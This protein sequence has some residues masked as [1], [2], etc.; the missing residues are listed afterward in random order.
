MLRTSIALAM[1]T[2]LSATAFAQAP[3][4]LGRP[5]ALSLA[6]VASGLAGGV[7]TVFVLDEVLSLAGVSDDV[8]V[9]IS[10]VTYPLGTSVGV[11]V[12]GRERGPDGTYGGAFRGA[13]R[14]AL[15]GY[16]AG[17]VVALA[18]VGTGRSFES[19]AAG[20]AVGLAVA[21]VGPPI[22]SALGYSVSAVSLRQPDGSA[23]GLSLRLDL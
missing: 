18:V 14:G 12:A 13:L 5:P 15:F 22:G 3:D 2:L 8:R 17:A 19:V 10:M 16:G 9:P 21:M 11:Y 6:L 23:P 7:V 1:A 4:S 20:V